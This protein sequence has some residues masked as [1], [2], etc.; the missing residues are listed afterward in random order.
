M[1]LAER[2]T[3]H[4]L[5]SIS[6]YGPDGNPPR[7]GYAQSR[8]RQVVGQ[9]IY[10][11]QPVLIAFTV[12]DYVPDFGSLADAITLCIQESNGSVSSGAD[13]CAPFS[14]PCVE[15]LAATFCAHAGAEPVCFLAFLDAGL[16]CALH[17]YFLFETDIAMEGAGTLLPCAENVN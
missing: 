8:V 1:F 16:I 10:G 3:H 17:L 11:E 13:A 5:D 4:P 7:Y 15:N 6:I 12:F 9:C 14:A 2:F